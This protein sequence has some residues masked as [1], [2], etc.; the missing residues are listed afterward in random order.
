MLEA[1]SYKPLSEKELL[2][3]H[4]HSISRGCKIRKRFYKGRSDKY[5][6]IIGGYCQTHK[7]E[8]CH[9]GWEWYWHYGKYTKPIHPNLYPALKHK[10]QK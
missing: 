3:P 1:Q 5:P 9:C 6:P 10:K 4:F 7:V 2:S 8:I